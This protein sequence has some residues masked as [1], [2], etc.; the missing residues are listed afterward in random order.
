[1]TG[2]ERRNPQAT[3]TKVTH[4]GLRALAPD[5]PWDA[6]GSAMGLKDQENLLVRQPRFLQELSAMVRD[7][8]LV[9]WQTY[10]KVR[11][12]DSHAPWLSPAFERAHFAFHQA[13]LGGT[14]EP[15]PRWQRVVRAADRALGE[16][17]GQ[18]FV[19]RAFSPRAKA[20][21]EDLVAHVR[22]AL[23]ERIGGLDWMT[24]PTKTAALHKLAAM[25]V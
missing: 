3:Y 7:T 25:G 17:L 19:A 21:A 1:M 22:T 14:Q 12:V 24:G 11:L 8:P 18:M 23:A 6:Y 13:A 5:F 4:E 9:Q 10:L 16:A 20:R 2:V 15:A